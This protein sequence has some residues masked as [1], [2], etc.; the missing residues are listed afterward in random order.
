MITR[1]WWW[2]QSTTHQ[3]SDYQDHESPSCT[4]AS[5]D[6]PTV[7]CHKTSASSPAPDSGT[8][9]VA[10]A[11]AGLAALRRTE[12]QAV[13]QIGGNW[14]QRGAV[15]QR[16]LGVHL[17][18]PMNCLQMTWSSVGKPT[19]TTSP[20]ACTWSIHITSKP[21]SREFIQCIKCDTS[22]T[23]ENNRA[24]SRCL[25]HLSVLSVTSHRIADHRSVSCKQMGRQ[26]QMPDAH[27]SWGNDAWSNKDVVD[28]PHQRLECSSSSVRK[29]CD[30][31]LWQLC[32]IDTSLNFTRSGKSSH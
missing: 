1:L 18:C 5:V 2:T 11:L 24:L 14:E 32:T 28:W 21:V 6:P 20:T 16:R 25:N 10:A 19:S 7:S 4:A 27:T 3:T 13:T 15:K 29:P 12:L 9:V 26:Q 22:N 17:A 31:P 8:A 23:S 30:A